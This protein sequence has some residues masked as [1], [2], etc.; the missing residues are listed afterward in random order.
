MARERKTP[1]PDPRFD[2]SVNGIRDPFAMVTAGHVR[3]MRPHM[4]AAYCLLWCK[5]GGIQEK[6]GSFAASYGELA[7]VLGRSERKTVDVMRALAGGGWVAV[8]GQS[9]YQGRRRN[10]WRIAKDA[11]EAAKIRGDG[12]VIGGVMEASPREMLDGQSLARPEAGRVRVPS[13]VLEVF[14]IDPS[15]IEKQTYGRIPSL[16]SGTGREVAHA[17][18]DTGEMAPAIDDVRARWARDGG[19]G[20]EGDEDQAAGEP[21]AELAWLAEANAHLARRRPAPA[22]ASCGRP[23]ERWAVF[24]SVL[25]SRCLAAYDS[26]GGEAGGSAAGS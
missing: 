1:K 16:R 9:V 19:H 11:K 12:T 8:K 7:T 5:Y 17:P 6:A 23:A 18:G 14:P 24:G 10:R 22:C 20:G 4:L 21:G 15:L 2:A 26:V 3:G 25:C 13:E